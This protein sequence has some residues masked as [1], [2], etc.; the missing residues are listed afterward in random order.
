MLLCTLR[1]LL[2]A[3]A[4]P[5]KLTLVRQLAEVGETTTSDLIEHCW[6]SL[7]TIRRHLRALIVAEIVVEKVGTSTGLTPGRPPARF[8]LKPE[9][10]TI[11]RELLHITDA[12][13]IG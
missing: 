3:V 2:D 1:S 7:P 9:V 13:R 12:Q 4:D 5:V 11:A 8:A 6:A 10:E